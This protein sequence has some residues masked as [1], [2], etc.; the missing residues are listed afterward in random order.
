M[1]LRFISSAG[2][3]LSVRAAAN[4]FNFVA[5]GPVFTSTS[6]RIDLYPFAS[7]N[8]DILTL[9]VTSDPTGATFLGISDDQSNTA[10]TNS[11]VISGAF[12]GV[13][14]TESVLGASNVILPGIPTHEASGMISVYTNGIFAT[15][16]ITLV[17]AAALVDRATANLATLFATGVLLFATSAANYRGQF[18]VATAGTTAANVN[19]ALGA[20]TA[21]AV[22][23]PTFLGFKVLETAD[24][25]LEGLGD[26]GSYEGK[27]A[28]LFALLKI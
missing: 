20:G 15:S 21:V 26:A 3:P 27:T 11:T 24:A 12:G 2:I 19:T 4:D 16:S 22:T 9:A 5:G 10:A 1:S 6:D 23:A 8:G 25:R 28:S 18:I 7:N 13:R 14:A 17:N